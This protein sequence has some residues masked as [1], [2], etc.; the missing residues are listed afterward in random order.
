M[1]EGQLAILAQTNAMLRCTD[2]SQMPKTVQA[3]G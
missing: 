3:E 2:Q 1:P